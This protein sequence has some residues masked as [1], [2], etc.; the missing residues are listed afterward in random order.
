LLTLTFLLVDAAG[1]AGALQGQDL[2][3]TGILRDAV[4]N[5]TLPYVTVEV[6]STG[7]T[8]V[9]NRDGRFALRKLPAGVVVLRVTSIGYRPAEIEVNVPEQ[10]EPL[11]IRLE[12]LPVELEEL[13]VIAEADR[14][15]KTGEQVSQVALS[16]VELKVLPSI[17]EVDIFR[18]LQLMPGVSG[19]NEASA[20]LF[21]RG[22]TPDQNLVLFDG[23]TVYHVD[24]FF[25]FFSA[26]NAD[27]VKDVRLF[28]GGYPARYGGRTSSVVDLT[29]RTG[30]NQKAHVAAGVNMLSAQGVVE[31]PLGGR[32]SIFLAA[33]RS[34]TDLLQS[35]LYED[36]FGM[37]SGGNTSP[38]GFAPA[39][40]PGR[41]ANTQ[42]AEVTPEFFF[43]DLNGKA[44][45]NPSIN[46]VL[47][48][49]VYSGR[50]NLDRSRDLSRLA[51]GQN[52]NFSTNVVGDLTD[53][54]DWGNFG[55]SGK[56]SR[57]WNP[58]F[59]SHAVAATSVYDS[60]YGRLTDTELWDE[61]ADTLIR[62]M[63]L[64]TSEDN[65]VTDLTFRLDNEWQAADWHKL[66][67]GA[68][69]SRS[70]VEYLFTRDDT[71]TLLDLDQDGFEGGF[72]LQD[73]WQALPRLAL[74]L[75]A[76]AS[77]YDN[78]GELYV[79]P[80]ASLTY[81]ASDRVRLK[82]AYGQYHQFVNRV[83]NQNVT[84]GS[85]DFWLLAGEEV[86]VSSAQHYVLGASY[87]NSG[88]LFDAEVF[89]KDLQGLSEFSLRFRRTGVEIE[90]LFFA[91]EG[92]AQGFELLAQK[93]LGRLSGWVSYTYSRVRHQFPDLNGGEEFPALHDVPHEFNVVGNY[94]PGRW[95]LS[96]TWAY[97]T[98][99]P[100]T[101]PE[102]IYTLDLLDG[103]EQS[104]IHVGEKNAERLPAYHRLDIAAYY[105][106]ELGIW[107]G[108]FG[109]SVFNLYD[110]V[111]VWYRE[112]DL[113]V[114]PPLVTDMTYL[115]RALSL[116]V[117]IER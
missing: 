33:R 96:A 25:G 54:T 91:G 30:D 15:M 85:R 34:Y 97:S 24:H 83:I 103:T 109:I 55:V 72:Y 49:S 111:N 11:E 77:Y 35:S 107:R 64:G 102:S 21:V 87:E 89:H 53:Q 113:S 50:D 62:S 63:Y 86:P 61:E 37:L 116:S 7:I 108:D 14:L 81:E 42:R 101:S 28:K 99:R 44:T 13:E 48:L 115:G 43:Y 70:T 39:G 92:Y 36:I 75:G 27:A 76:R 31:V 6:K 73:T 56:W 23:M 32:G 3:L 46:D 78:S 117:R 88:F 51:G 41:F 98:G 8:A 68:W 18:S 5:E 29:G 104:Y 57:Q 22:G 114:D 12:R 60:K 19:T 38:I 26:F 47:A 79:E 40:A 74:N 10:S 100:Y 17:G 106:F 105:R 110:R 59:Y 52:T 1:F 20:G 93:K 4:N 67:F 66:D 82:G 94:T 69:L 58:F 45:Y 65:A 95:N 16:P 112:F 71:T 84:E 90:E 80:R 2:T 9:S